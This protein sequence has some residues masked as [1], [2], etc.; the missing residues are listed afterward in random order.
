MRYTSFIFF[1]AILLVSCGAE[2]EGGQLSEEVVFVMNNAAEPQSLDPHKI[3]GVPENRVYKAFFQGLVATDPVTARAVAGM[4]ESWS[5]EGPVYTMK[6][7]KGLVWSDGVAITAQ[8]VRNSWLRGLDPETASPYA[9]FPSM[10]IKGAGDYNKGTAGPESVAIEAVDDHTFR[11]ETV[12][13]LPYVIGALA[14]YSFAVVPLHTI[15]EYGNDWTKPEYF[16]GNGP[17]VLTQ[18]SPQEILV[19]KKNDKFWNRERVYIDR[20]E[21]FPVEDANTVFN[22]YENGEIDWSA[23]LVPTEQFDNLR[24]REDLYISPQLGTYYYIFNN[25]RAPFDDVRV[26]KAL[27]LSIGREDIADKVLGEGQIPAYGFVPPMDNY[28]GIDAVPEDL[29]QA[30]RLLAE[31]GFPDGQNFPDFTIL[32]NTREDHKKVAEFVQQR[33]KETLGIDVELVNQE[34]KTYLETRNKGEYDIA[35]GG[36]VGD[37]L[38][39]NTFLDMFVTGGGLNTPNYSNPRYDSLIFEA[40]RQQGEQRMATMRQA[41]DLL[42]NQDHVVVPIYFYVSRNLFNSSKWQGWYPNTMDYHPYEGLR[43]RN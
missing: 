13:D 2:K 8:T 18:W 4:A 40:A 1:T 30:Q 34:W 14:H 39:P 17:F 31:A 32:Y 28:Q 7:R 10:F 9:W 20:I 6:L 42:I 37:Y 15:D 27:S 36:W 23:D 3:S 38:D 5:N 33:W 29:A 12:G 26:R 43:L 25:T 19:G 21:F 11:F 24:G 22:M 41:E 35:R 16:V